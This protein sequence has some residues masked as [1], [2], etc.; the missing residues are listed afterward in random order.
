[1][2][3]SQEQGLGNLIKRTHQG[4]LAQQYHVGGWV[5]ADESGVAQ[6]LRPDE[7]ENGVALPLFPEHHVMEPLVR[8]R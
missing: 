4:Q 3:P 1:M 6:D 5:A 8:P 2:V 7:A